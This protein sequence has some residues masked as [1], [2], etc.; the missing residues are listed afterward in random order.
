MKRLFKFILKTLIGL[1]LLAIVLAALLQT[2]MGKGVLA[3]ALSRLASRPGDVEV[4]IGR[5]RGWVPMAMQVERVRISDAS[6]TWLD[7]E[8]L[9]ARWMM[10]DLLEGRIRLT[11]LGADQVEWTRLPKTRTMPGARERRSSEGVSD[12]EFVLEGWAIDRLKLGADLAGVP[13]EYS[14]R[15]GGIVLADSRLQG[16]L[17]I[18]GDAEGSVDI[19]A[20]LADATNR[21]LVIRAELRQ[22]HKPTFGMDRLAGT[23]TA[24]ID[25]GGVRASAEA[26]I[27][28]DETRGHAALNLH[29]A[30]RRLR[31]DPFRF[32]G[33]GYNANAEVDLVFTNDGIVAAADALLTDADDRRYNLTGTASVLTTTNWSVQIPKLTLR[34]WDAATLNVSG[35]FSR[36]QVDLEAHLSDIDLE[37]FPYFAATNFEGRVTGAA[38][39]SGTP[40][41]PRINASL[42]ITGFTTASDALDELPPL[43]FGVSVQFSEER[44]RA[45]TTLTNSLSGYLSA[46]ASLPCTFSIVPFRFDM[47]ADELR[48]TLDA[49]LD[50]AMFNGLS[51]MK[52]QFVRGLLSAELDLT[53]GRPSG[54]VYIE[55]GSYEHYAWGIL[56]RDFHGALNATP[57][58]FTLQDATATDGGSGQL[59]LTGGI[60]S[61]R[62]DLALNLE[63]ALIIR[64]PE[65]EAMISGRLG[66]SGPVS[67]PEIEGQ[68]VVE[69]A[70]LLPDNITA[71]RPQQ[72]DNYDADGPVLPTA[73]EEL[74]R[75]LPVGLD[76]KLDMPDQVNINA[77]LIDSVWSGVLLLQDSPKGLW[78]RG[79]I[80]PRRGYVNFIGKKFRFVD[81]A[82]EID[83][84]VLPVP[85]LSRLT[86]E[87]SRS[88]ITARLILNGSAVDPQYRLE[89]SPA[90]P[91]D[92]VLAQILFRRD[93]S[94]ITAYQ[95]VQLAMAAQQLSGGLGGPG[96]LFQFRQAVGVDSIE[97]RES[98]SAEEGSSIAVGQYI[99]S[100]LYIEVSSSFGANSRTDM[101]AEYE[102]NRNFSLETSVGPEMRPGIG[103]NWR[104][105]Y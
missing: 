92:E 49:F 18:S 101:T 13:L 34:A 11:E 43:D 68:L 70:D 98:E 9:H 46:E 105:E 69:R 27:E 20:S 23:F 30:S 33:N 44:L 72:L 95:A 15:S 102:L 40:A 53:G 28:K 29:Y 78:I 51:V 96:F 39:I 76:V 31:I 38:A 81:G 48:G 24:E 10:T 16:D 93:S 64:R 87:Y 25:A 35:G 75:P 17:S 88:D 74:R 12:I 32:D 60:S 2:P 5:I 90:L 57:E 21:V 63:D 56:F 62:L 67:R 50:L 7:L 55:D 6:G 26:H 73:E 97:W 85:V 4:H 66:I 99:T 42:G 41:D 89:S 84:A 1:L 86:A 47:Q 54:Y 59:E 19:S 82:V 61:G 79:S 45:S 80:E 52:N 83:T 8:N 14:V 94:S 58:G 77:S 36:Q 100:D 37:S 104:I 91:E 65:A 103:L 3:S 71:P 22:M